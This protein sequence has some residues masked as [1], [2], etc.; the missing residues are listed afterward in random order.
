MTVRPMGHDALG[1]GYYIN[2]D[3][4]TST[5]W[6]AVQWQIR[7]FSAPS[8]TRDLINPVLTPKEVSLAD[9][10]SWTNA[11]SSALVPVISGTFRYGN[12]TTPWRA[13]DDEI[14][15]IQTDAAAGA[16]ATVW[17][18][19]HHRSIVAND[20]NPAAT[21]FWYEPRLIVSQDGRWAL[22]TSN[23]DKTLG[24]DPRGEVGGTYRQ[25]AFVVELKASGTPLTPPIV[26]PI[27]IAPVTVPDATVGSAYSLALSSTGG[28]QPIRWTV[29]N[30]VLPAR[31]PPTGRSRL[32]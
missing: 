29:L 17:R 27:Q 21:Y 19:A 24:T 20:N 8:T 30:G 7:S 1:Y 25:D 28:A 10:Q 4:C 5:T 13:M 11:Q 22:F 23:W 16:T 31:R 14:I 9:H 32:R 26:A 3:C 15:A 18:F 6:D 2:Q 12:N